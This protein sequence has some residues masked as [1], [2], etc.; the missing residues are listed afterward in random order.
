MASVMRIEVSPIV[1]TGCDEH[2]SSRAPARGRLCVGAN[3]ARVAERGVALTGYG[4]S[5]DT[6]L[7]LARPSPRLA[8]SERAS[9][10]GVS[11]QPPA[12]CGARDRRY[13]SSV[14][15]RQPEP[16]RSPPYTCVRVR[17]LPRVS[18][19]ARPSALGL[20]FPNRILRCQR[21]KCASIVVSIW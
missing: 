18:A 15:P 4:A 9:D 13:N 8:H 6:P 21:K 12:V 1:K 2:W 20:F 14:A 3:T 5:V 11:P 7:H 17:P 16:E 19:V 10:T